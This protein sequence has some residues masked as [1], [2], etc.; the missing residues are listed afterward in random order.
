MTILVFPLKGIKYSFFSF[1]SVIAVCTCRQSAMS[2]STKS[3]PK[4]S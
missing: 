4:E 2:Q 1:Q 3:M